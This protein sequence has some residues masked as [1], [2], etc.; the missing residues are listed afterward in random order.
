MARIGGVLIVLAGVA[1][2]VFVVKQAPSTGAQA[3]SSQTAALPVVFPPGVKLGRM[4]RSY[5]VLEGSFTLTN[6]NAF[7][8]ADA[9]IIC[10]I[11][12]PSGTVVGG[13]RFTIYDVV[14]AK[15]SK[16]VNAYKFGSWPQQG[17]SLSCEANKA[18]R[19]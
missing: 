16:A 17:K 12:A 15:K 18:R 13:Y 14:A 3:V 9:E 2:I 5:G 19:A 1:A 10:E 6:E 11:T 7:A 8:I 4:D